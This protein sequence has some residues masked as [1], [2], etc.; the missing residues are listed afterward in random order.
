MSLGFLNT[1]LRITDLFNFLFRVQAINRFYVGISE[2]PWLKFEPDTFDYGY[3]YALYTTLIN[4]TTT[5]GYFLVTL[6]IQVPL[7]YFMIAFVFMLK[8]FSDGVKF[9]NIHGWDVEGSGKLYEVALA[10][11][12]IGTAISHMILFNQCFWNK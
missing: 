6:R 8:L 9:T 5:F 2:K 11:A 10:R 12:Q 1:L 4:V 3:Y 7:L